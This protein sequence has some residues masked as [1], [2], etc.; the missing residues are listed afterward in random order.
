MTNINEL[1]MKLRTEV[2]KDYSPRIPNKRFNDAVNTLNFFIEVYAIR[3][4]MDQVTVPVR[5]MQR[6]CSL[7][8]DGFEAASGYR[9]D[10]EKAALASLLDKTWYNFTSTLM[11]WV[12]EQQE[13]NPLHGELWYSCFPVPQWL[14]EA[15]RDDSVEMS[16]FM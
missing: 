3:G 13:L 7:G 2:L 9:Y 6:L 4:N 1:S 16:E 15:V 14:V 8:V 12:K 5:F 11:H 10:Q